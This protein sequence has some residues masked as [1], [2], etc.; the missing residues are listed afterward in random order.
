MSRRQRAHTYH[1]YVVFRRLPRCLPRC[2]KQRANIH[3]KS[4]VSKGCSNYLS[5][6]VMTVLAHFCDHYSRSAAFLL[7]ECIAHTQNFVHT[8]VIRVA[9]A[10]YAGNRFR[11][12]FVPA[13]YFFHSHGNLSQAG[14]CARCCN[15]KLQKVAPAAFGTFCKCF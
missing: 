5:T 2:L 3:I 1:M 14:P 10:V 7:L 11:R 8:V 13:K 15:G 12:C 4:Q 9:T 6:P